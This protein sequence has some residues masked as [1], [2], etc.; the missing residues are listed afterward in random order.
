MNNRGRPNVL[1]DKVAVKEVIDLIWKEVVLIFP[2]QISSKGF[3]NLMFSIETFEASFGAPSNAKFPWHYLII[4]QG[5]HV[6]MVD[7]KPLLFW[8]I[9]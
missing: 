8:I 4:N 5:N 9:K 7:T 3:K 1:C 2:Y 6:F